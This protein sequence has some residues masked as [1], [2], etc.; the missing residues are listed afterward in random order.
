MASQDVRAGLLT[1]EEGFDLARRYDA[2]RPEA[3]DQYLHLSGYTEE[4]FYRIMK[5][6]RLPMLQDQPIDPTTPRD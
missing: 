5:E 1:R 4:E 3:L 2:K 6:K